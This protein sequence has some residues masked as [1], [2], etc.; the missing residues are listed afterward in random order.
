MIPCYLTNRD[1]LSPVRGMVDHLLGCD[2]VG[3]VTILDCGSTY[4]PLLEWYALE[5]PC[6]VRVV[7][8]PNLGCRALWDSGEV[9]RGQAYFASDADLDLR[10]VPKDF[11]GVLQ[12]GLS[13]FPDAVKCGL[14][15]RLHD[16]PLDAYL[17]N[18]AIAH[19]FPYWTQPRAEGWFAANIDTTAAMYRAGSGWGGYGPALRSAPPYSARHLPWYLTPETFTEEWQW[20]RDHC[21]KSVSTWCARL[22]E[23]RV[24]LN[25]QTGEKTLEGIIC[26]APSFSRRTTRPTSST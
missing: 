21:D 10:G 24:W 12:T 18:A 11:L 13:F 22:P 26:V 6:E 5:C 15:L 9:P 4:A 1:L 7:R 16:I 2:G 3:L 19:E 8:L 25:R 20:Y 17:R 23:S 14:S